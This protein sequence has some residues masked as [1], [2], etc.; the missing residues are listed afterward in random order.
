MK[1]KIEYVKICDAVP[2]VKWLVL[3][4]LLKSSQI[5]T[6]NFYHRKNWKRAH[7]I[8]NKQKKYNK[9]PEKAQRKW[10]SQKM[11]FFKVSTKLVNF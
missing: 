8:Q 1:I 4:A 2:E 9:G 10:I 3:K 5:N 7:C 11:D 6:V